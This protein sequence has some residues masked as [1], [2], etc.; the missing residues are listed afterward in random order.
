[1]AQITEARLQQPPKMRLFAFQAVNVD[2][3]TIKGVMEAARPDEVREALAARGMRVTEIK[4]HRRV[5][6]GEFLSSLVKV[7]AQEVIMFCRQL[8]TFVRVGIPI[9]TALET[10]AEG[11]AN[12]RMRNACAGMVADLERGSLLSTAMARHPAVLPPLLPDLVRAA[13]MT[14]HLDDVLLRAA[15]H[16][17]REAEAKRKIRAA[18]TYPTIVFLMAL[19]V[20]A[21]LV[22]FVLP[23]FR[24]L[25]TEFNAKIPGLAAF[26]LDLSAFIG[27]HAVSILIGILVVVLGGGYLARRDTGRLRLAQTLLHVPVIAP[28]LRAVAVERFCRSL[29]DMLSAG[30]PV[31]TSFGVV[32]DSTRNPVY[33]RALTTVG[34]EV[35]AGESF[36]RALKRTGV[37]PPMVTQMVR[38]GEDTGTLDEHLAVTARMYDDELDYRLKRLTSIVEPVMIISV[39]VLV[40]I[41]AVS[42]VQAIYGF[43]SAIK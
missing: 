4:F 35:A 17:E 19:A 42:L 30:V 43:V 39:G 34:S 33:R 36:S 14:G 21:G 18:L 28:M 13:E 2:G 29:S 24:D 31:G 9:T 22:L 37:F 6:S 3:D 20:A 25:F 5:I 26:L 15:A 27:D 38:V 41:V 8:A 11:T 16:F 10:I 32:I 12:P 7:K 1:M 23:K 40:G